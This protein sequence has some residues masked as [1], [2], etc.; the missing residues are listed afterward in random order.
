METEEQRLERL[1]AR[2]RVRAANKEAWAKSPFNSNARRAATLNAVLPPPGE[3][4]APVA[5]GSLER[6]RAI[7][8]DPDAE[9]YRRIDAAE[10]VLGYELSPA[11]L[12]NADPTI[13]V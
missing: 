2:E 6:L 1:A 7:M 13:P 8:T 4:D 3:E 12:A 10:I 5:S 11:A 9:L